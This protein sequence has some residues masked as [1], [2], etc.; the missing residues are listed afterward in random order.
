MECIFLFIYYYYLYSF[1]FFFLCFYILAKK[2]R[3]IVGVGFTLVFQVSQH[4]RDEGILMS[5]VD[6]FSCGRYVQR[7]S[8]EWGHYSCTKFADNYSIKEFFDKY[9]IRGAKAKDFADW[10]KAAKIIK[11]GGH[12]TIEGAT[13]INN[14]KA[15]MNTN[16]TEDLNYI[17]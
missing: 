1:F 4:L 13:E 9:P 7:K 11:N 10:T 12:L 14:L 5:L 6:Y 17:A 8:T 3:N 2:G 16:R 15:G